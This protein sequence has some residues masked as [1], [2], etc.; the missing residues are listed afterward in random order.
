MWG[1]NLATD[2]RPY[3]FGAKPILR[4]QSPRPRCVPGL[5]AHETI[6]KFPRL[7][8]ATICRARGHGGSVR[9]CSDFCSHRN[10]HRMDAVVDRIWGMPGGWVGGMGMNARLEMLGAVLGSG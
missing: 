1:L 10:S 5:A 2:S 9:N 8:A 3:R 6:L 4:E 7:T